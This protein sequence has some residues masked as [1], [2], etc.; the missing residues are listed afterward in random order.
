MS[1][2]LYY[3]RYGERFPCRSCGG[4]YLDTEGDERM[5]FDLSA[6]WS[7]ITGQLAGAWDFLLATLV[8]PFSIV[9]ALL[10]IDIPYV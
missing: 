7:V 3:M 1:K 5:C 9:E 8:L 4:E 6:A 2:H 10:C